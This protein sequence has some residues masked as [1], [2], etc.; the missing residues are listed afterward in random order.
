MQAATSGLKR[1]PSEAGSTHISARLSKSRASRLDD[2]LES[3][4]AHAAAAVV[5]KNKEFKIVRQRLDIDRARLELL[6]EERLAH[7]A[8]MQANTSF[9]LRPM[10]KLDK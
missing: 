4:K 3:K 7:I 8:T 2:Y 6:R 10:D 9:L 1:K 5:L